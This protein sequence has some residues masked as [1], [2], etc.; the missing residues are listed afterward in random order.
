MVTDL[1]FGPSVDRDILVLD[2]RGVLPRLEVEQ[3]IPDQIHVTLHVVA[4]AVACVGTMHGVAFGQTDLLGPSGS[5]MSS[6]AS[7]CIAPNEAI[8]ASPSSASPDPAPSR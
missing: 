1:K 7:P 3:Q 2:Q 5:A 8:N 6:T 4:P